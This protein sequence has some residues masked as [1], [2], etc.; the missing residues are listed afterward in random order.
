MI[1]IRN[2]REKSMKK[3]KKSFPLMKTNLPYWNSI[4]F[5]G[6]FI[7]VAETFTISQFSGEKFI[8]FFDWKISFLI[9]LW[10]TDVRVSLFSWINRFWTTLLSFST[11]FW[12]G[13]LLSQRLNDRWFKF[14][15]TLDGAFIFLENKILDVRVFEIKFIKVVI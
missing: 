14:V 8:H 10:K 9:H 6:K 7:Y 5:P 1:S 3:S 15:K 12:D 2:F 11:L 4:A 13:D